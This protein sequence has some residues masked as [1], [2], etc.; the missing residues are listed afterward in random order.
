MSSS[1]ANPDLK[2]RCFAV[3]RKVSSAHGILPKSHHLLNVTLSGDNAHA[4]GGSTDIWKGQ[5]SGQQ[6][7]VKVFRTQEVDKP[8]R[9]C[10]LTGGWTQPDCDQ[11]LY[12]IILGWKYMTHPNVV[13]FLG[14]TET[15]DYPFCFV[16][17]WLP[18]GNIAKYI[19]KKPG[20]NRFQLVSILPPHSLT[21]RLKHT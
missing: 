21:S 3:L 14:V 20:V 12:R 16:N 18:N 15:P 6:V 19:P 2:G 5:F 13:P 17:H 4:S 8:V 7:C 10:V 1:A 11:R 9:Y